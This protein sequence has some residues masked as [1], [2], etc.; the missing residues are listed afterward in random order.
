MTYKY[1]DGFKIRNQ[2]GLH[3]L[4]FTIMGWVDVFTR[5]CYTD[6]I[7]DS[8]RFCQEKKGLKVG[9]WVIMSNLIHI[10]WRAE[11]NNLS[12]LVRDFKTFTSKAIFEII[13]IE[14]ES[15]REWLNYMFRYFANGNNANKQIK[16][17][18]NNNHPE[19]IF[20]QDFLKTKLDYIHNNPV[21]AGWV[22]N[23]SDYIYSSA[24]GYEGKKGLIELD[25]LM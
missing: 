14:N 10:I 19:E 6:L 13:Q 7:L 1:T 3:F 23:P 12:D 5:Q 21:R 17:W 24:L 16:I 2:A 22:L 15:R 4:T 9:A 11:D 25:Y 20:T 8:F 18:T